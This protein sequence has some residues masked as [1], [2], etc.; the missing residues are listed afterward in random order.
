MYNSVFV[1]LLVRFYYALSRYY[2]NSFLKKVVS[3][4]GIFFRKNYYSSR[5]LKFNKNIKALF[6][7][8]RFYRL[9]LRLENGLDRLFAHL[10]RIFNKLKDGSNFDNSISFYL[11]SFENTFRLIYYIF[12][13]IGSIMCIFGLL[14]IF[15]LNFKIGILIIAIGAIGILINGHEIDILKGSSFL[16]FFL[17]LFKLD[18]G[19]YRWW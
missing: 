10:N 17:D 11:D 13:I 3:T 16:G 8:S 6:V 19:E 12:I 2:E 14:N 9:F 18:G 5:F 7:N 15:S 4:I 1:G